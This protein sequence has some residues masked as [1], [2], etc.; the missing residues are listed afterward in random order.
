MNSNSYSIMD[1]LDGVKG[2]YVPDA[3]YLARKE[4]DEAERCTTGGRRGAPKARLNGCDKYAIE[5]K[6]F[7]F[8]LENGIKPQD[9]SEYVFQSFMSTARTLKGINLDALDMVGK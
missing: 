1:F 8:F 6:S 4:T 5:L 9:V 2:E 7:I 3:I